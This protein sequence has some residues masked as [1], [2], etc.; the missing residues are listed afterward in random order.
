ML[1]NF[2]ATGAYVLVVGLASVFLLILLL[3]KQRGGKE[4]CLWL[5][6]GLVGMLLGATIPVAI[7]YFADYKPVKILD[8]M[9]MSGAGQVAGPPSFEEPAAE[10]PAAEEPVAEEPS[11][12]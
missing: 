12:E 6:S 8:S 3:Q 1:F 9:N 5:F 11:E 10:E 7:C 2:N 4:V